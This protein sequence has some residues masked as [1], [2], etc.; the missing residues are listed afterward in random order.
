M[1]TLANMC[2]VVS[3]NKSGNSSLF[4]RRLHFSCHMLHVHRLVK[5]AVTGHG[6]PPSVGI[7]NQHSVDRPTTRTYN[8][9]A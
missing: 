5:F 3:L 1:V 8:M 2:L 6:M 7:T 9:I 4:P